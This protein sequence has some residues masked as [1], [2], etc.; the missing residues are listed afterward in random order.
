MHEFIREALWSI[1]ELDFYPLEALGPP[2]G[3]LPI[4]EHRRR[5]Y[6]VL[7]IDHVPSEEADRRDAT[8]C[9]VG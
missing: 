6:S 1:I 8:P 5:N 4:P 9:G 7:S 2:L 3:E